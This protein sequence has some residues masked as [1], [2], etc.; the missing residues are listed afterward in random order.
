M[1]R[2]VAFISCLAFLACG[3]EPTG[4]NGGTPDIIASVSVEG[5]NRQSARPQN[6]MPDSVVGRATDS[7]GRAVQGRLINFTIPAGDSA[8]SFAARALQTNAQGRVFNE[9]TAGTKA[10][11]SRVVNGQDSAYTARLV[12]S[13]EGRPDEIATM[14]FSVLPGE[15]VVGADRRDNTGAG[16]GGLN[17]SN[18]YTL[19]ADVHGAA[20]YDEHGNPVRWGLEFLAVA[21]AESA[22]DRIGGLR[23]VV[24]D[25]AGC[26]P[27]Y[28]RI[29]GGTG[30]KADS[31]IIHV[32]TAGEDLDAEILIGNGP[33]REA[34]KDHHECIEPYF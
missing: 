15:P 19:P 21:H 24:T 28:V 22:Q 29:D 10:W 1:R 13:R 32:Q 2:L 18:T 17:G 7:Q 33:W 14:T 26:A 9:L 30:V 3:S 4:L 20:V 23:K 8:G 5:G 34:H 6:P 16:G 12:A 31:G 11:T 25:S 27:L